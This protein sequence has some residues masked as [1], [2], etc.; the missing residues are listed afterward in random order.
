MSFFTGLFGGIFKATAGFFI[1][2]GLL[3]GTASVSTTTTPNAPVD[4]SQTFQTQNLNGTS[5][6]SETV[7][8]QTTA[9]SANPTPSTTNTPKK[10]SANTQPQV[11]PQP[12]A[13]PVLPLVNPNQSY[14]VPQT[15]SGQMQEG[16]V[17][18]FSYDGQTYDYTN[19]PV[20]MSTIPQSGGWTKVN[21]NYGSVWVNN[22]DFPQP[23][24]DMCNGTYYPSYCSAGQVF[25][26]SNNSTASC[27]SA[28]QAAAE[29]QAAAQQQLQARAQI[30]AQMALQP[31]VSQ[32]NTDLTTMQS[33][34]GVTGDRT[35][36]PAVLDMQSVVQ[37]E[38]E[39]GYMSTVAATQLQSVQKIYSTL[40]A[41]YYA[42]S[43]N[44]IGRGVTSS[45][46]TNCQQPLL[47]PMQGILS[48]EGG[49][50][51]TYVPSLP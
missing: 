7:Q 16:N 24:S 47:S 25:V 18:N 43:T 3:H 49:L 12:Q 2:I 15:S 23:T 21:T 39:T 9:P 44:A 28:S 1:A 48:I 20:G 31:Y 42:C 13:Q 19:L 11:T 5:T 41:D 33:G 51:A 40:V 35:C 37:N 50:G 22:N 29:S 17:E 36:D 4:L 30:Q 6:V 10:S 38:A 46:I 8:T 26:C 34:C 32:F 27:E 14:V 45:A